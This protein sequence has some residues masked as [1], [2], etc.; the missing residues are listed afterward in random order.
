MATSATLVSRSPWPL[1]PSLA[2]LSGILRLR[3]RSTRINL[4]LLTVP[5]MPRSWATVS[6]PTWS[7][8]PTWARACSTSTAIRPTVFTPRSRISRPRLRPRS[9]PATACSRRTPPFGLATWSIRT[10]TV[11]VSSTRT[12]APTSVR[13][14]PSSPSV[15]PTPSVTRTST[16]ASSS[17][18]L[19]ATRCSTTWRWSSRTWT[20]PGPTSLLTCSTAPRWLPSILIRITRQALTVAMASSFG[21]GMMTSPTCASTRKANCL[22]LRLW[23]RTTTTASA[24]VTLRTAVT[25]VWRT[26]L[27]VTRSPSA[28]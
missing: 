9:I 3:F 17:T 18:A 4:S 19:M 11:T 12:T 14:C 16:W 15:G 22:A 13:R 20:R 1:T 24:T 27:W 2:R 8:W 10:W 25:S 28:S 5:T 21:T 23:T 26:S 6:G 7:A